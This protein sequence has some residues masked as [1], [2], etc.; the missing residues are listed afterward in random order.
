MHSHEIDNQAANKH[1]NHSSQQLELGKWVVCASL[2]V[3]AY[4]QVVGSTETGHV[5][6]NTKKWV[7]DM[8][9]GLIPFSFSIAQN[10]GFDG[11]KTLP[12]TWKRKTCFEGRQND[13]GIY[14][15]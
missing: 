12:S 11:K 8:K 10:E 15:M 7:R 6:E 9:C 5:V 1:I 3:A 4:W 14:H 13:K 2:C